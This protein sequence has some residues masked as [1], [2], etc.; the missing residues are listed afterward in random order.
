MPLINQSFRV[1]FIGHNA[2]TTK[3]KDGIT[4]QQPVI[5]SNTTA[6]EVIFPETVAKNS[7]TSWWPQFTKWLLKYHV[8]TGYILECYDTNKLSKHNSS[9]E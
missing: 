2:L 6:L 9:K 7:G 1:I 8:F 4:G 3:A 5:P